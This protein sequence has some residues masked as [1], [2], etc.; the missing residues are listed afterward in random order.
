MDVLNVWNE[1]FLLTNF[2]LRFFH[3][4]RRLYQSETVAKEVRGSCVGTYQLFITLGILVGYCAF[5]D[6]Y[7]DEERKRR[8][9]R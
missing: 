8:K 2:P 1:L 5:Y 9:I 6:A 4:F 7:F 3:P